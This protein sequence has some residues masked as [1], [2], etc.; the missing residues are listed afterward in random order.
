MFKTHYSVG[1]SILK[2]KQIFS[3][4]KHNDLNKLIFVEDSFSG[5]RKIDSLSKEL[6]IPFIFGIRLP[7]VQESKDELPS[8]L[9]F[10][11][12]NSE[13]VLNCKKIFTKCMVESD[14]VLILKDLSKEDLEHIRIGVPFYDS[15]IYN[16]IFH[17]GLSS[18]NLKKLDHFYIEEDNKHPFDF[19]IKNVLNDLGVKT[20]LSKSIYYENREDFS[21]FEFYKATCNRQGGRPPNS[22]SPN[23]NNFC[24]AEFSFESYLENK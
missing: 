15:Y 2:P 12:K 24:S 23:L 4:A 18:L 22:G 5:F 14:G 17:F 16:N 21:A 6:D 13:G 9:I 1:N 7:V 19:Q 3:L 10:F 8:K 20:V 11:S